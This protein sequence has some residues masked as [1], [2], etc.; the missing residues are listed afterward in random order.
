MYPV[1]VPQPKCKSLRKPQ[2]THSEYSRFQSEVAHQDEK[3]TVRVCMWSV[4]K[5]LKSCDVSNS[6][7]DENFE[8]VTECCDLMTVP[9]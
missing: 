6:D 7:W 1:S 9:F 2:H 3:L 8:L 4:E 5:I